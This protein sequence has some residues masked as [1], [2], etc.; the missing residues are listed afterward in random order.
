[1]FHLKLQRKGERHLHF[2]PFSAVSNL[3][4]PPIQ[5]QFA[6]RRRRLHRRT[7]EGTT[8][9]GWTWRSAWRRGTVAAALGA[10]CC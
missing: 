9:G 10:E 2:S 6:Q 8:Y 1:M 4:P 3:K 7:H 5:L